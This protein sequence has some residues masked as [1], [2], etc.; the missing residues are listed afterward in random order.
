MQIVKTICMKCQTLFFWKKKKK[1]KKE[2]DW[3]NDYLAY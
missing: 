3:K 2:K 1:K